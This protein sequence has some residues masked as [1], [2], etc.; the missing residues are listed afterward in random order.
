MLRETIVAHRWGGWAK[1]C[2]GVSNVKCDEWVEFLWFECE[3]KGFLIGSYELGFV[4][5]H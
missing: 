5:L 2:C 3:W 4:S 1:F